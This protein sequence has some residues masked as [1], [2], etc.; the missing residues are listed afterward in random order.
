MPRYVAE[1]DADTCIGSQMCVSIAPDSYVFDLHEGVSRF[2][3]GASDAA[4]ILEAAE[5]CPVQAILVRDTDD[6]AQV[7][8]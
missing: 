1:V 3:P 6:D 2:V 8:P 4:A 5:M 7:H